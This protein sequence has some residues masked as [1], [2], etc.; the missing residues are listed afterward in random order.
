MAQKQVKTSSTHQLLLLKRLREISCISFCAMS[1]F[2]LVAY[3][4]YSPEDSAWSYVNQSVA[5]QNAGGRLG[6][7]AADL[8]FLLFG[9]VSYLF[10]LLLMHAAIQ[11]M[12]EQKTDIYLPS[13]FFKLIGSLL[14]I[15]ASC[16]FFSLHIQQPVFSF[17]P[18]SAG[19]VF[20]SL[21]HKNLLPL[22]NSFGAT[23]FYLVGITIGLTLATGLSWVHLLDK[24]AETNLL[25]YLYY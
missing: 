23:L 17:L 14:F 3:C 4:T 25:F 5:I 15:M 20:G 16:G 12:R 11:V 8:S 2:L 13:W 9:L 21:L 24:L 6:A 10:P 7:F 19:G 1:L 18:T 22:L